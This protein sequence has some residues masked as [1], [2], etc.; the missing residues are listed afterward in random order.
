MVKWCPPFE[1][2]NT[3]NTCNKVCARGVD[4]RKPFNVSVRPD[5]ARYQNEDGW[6][7][8]ARENFSSNDFVFVLRRD[9]PHMFEHSSSMRYKIGER[10]AGDFQMPSRGA[11]FK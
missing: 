5:P 9:L 4:D 8:V 11:W 10:R 1:N 6:R 3:H 7:L 2:P